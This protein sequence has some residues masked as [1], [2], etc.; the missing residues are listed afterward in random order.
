MAESKGK[1]PGW[2]K[3]KWTI[4]FVVLLVIGGIY[5]FFFRHRAPAYQFTPV[6]RGTIVQ[7]V[8][9][10]GNTTPIA[11]VS[12]GFQN[13]GT[14]AR[15]DYKLGDTVGAGAVIASL[16]IANLS[17][18]L[19]EAQAT[20]ASAQAALDG[21]VAGTRP[22]QLAIDQ[23]AVAQDQIALRNAI[24]SAYTSSDTAVHAD[25]DPIFTNPRTASAALTI[26]VP[27]ATLA[28]R[29][30]DERVALEPVLTAWNAQVSSASFITSDPTGAAEQATQ[31][32]TQVSVFLNDLADALTKAQPAGSITATTLN[33]YKASIAA[34]RTSLATALSAL[35]TA[36]TA[37]AGAQ[38]TLALAQAGSTPQEIAQQ[39]AQVEQEQA[40]VAAAL[41]NLRNAEIVAPI[42]GTITE[43]D[44]KIG[45][46]ATAGT[47]LVS[48]LGTGG[49]EV[50]AGVSE[51]DIGKL[52]LGDTASM[53]LD[54]FP[55][56]TFSGT[57]FYIAAAQ[58]NDQ[59][60]ISYPIKIAFDK[61]DPRLKS[62]L[63]ANIDLE[64]K[65]KEDVLVLPQY[66]ILQNDNGTFVETLAKN[67]AVTTTPVTLGIQDQNG[68]VEVTSGVTEGEQVITVGLKTQ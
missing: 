52:A 27:D 36:Q 32:L 61:P 45:Q 51:T 68:N 54:A 46:L 67:G 60:V 43:Q 2:L 56:E 39:Q 8:S 63:T 64:T 38:G 25:A 66:A 24:T 35:T 18:A 14:I 15:V 13:S 12:L 57:V 4:G 59:G 47:P 65:K 55:G 29:V 21:L 23:N 5:W 33:T 34:D 31:N 40:G 3:S 17:A 62:G 53:T 42:R 44:A 50:D 26:T 30:V 20:L 16:N 28:T 1:M 7:T 6:T 58:T 37:L 41:A 48:I 10:T 22:E 9:V 49:F 19:Q 11:S